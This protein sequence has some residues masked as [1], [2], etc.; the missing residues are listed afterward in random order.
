MRVA[1]QGERTGRGRGAWRGG[2]G[3]WW[4]R[5]TDL[6]H[7]ALDFRLSERRLHRIQKASEVVFYVL[8]HKEDAASP[9]AHHEARGESEKAESETH[10]TGIAACR[11]VLQARGGGRGSCSLTD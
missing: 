6:Q 1:I 7:Q 4:G 8:K 10:E 2:E 9:A 5:G 3:R 11:L